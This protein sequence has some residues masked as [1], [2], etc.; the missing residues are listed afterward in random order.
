MPRYFFHVR[1]GVST[2]DETGTELSDLDQARIE[3]IQLTSQI[4]RDEARRIAR[5][6]DWFLEVTDEARLVL[7][8]FDFIS[9]E[10]PA[11]SRLR[12]PTPQE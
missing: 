2:P 9:Q 4:F 12:R 7:L 8:R 5:G 3:A 6:E 1:D 10:A 11:A